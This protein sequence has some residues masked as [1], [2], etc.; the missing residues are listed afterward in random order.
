MMH[1]M[2]RILLTSL[3][4]K[5]NVKNWQLKKHYLSVQLVHLLSKWARKKAEDS[6]Q[7]VSVCFQSKP[8]EKFI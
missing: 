4:S 5:L 8:H 7:F 6:M 2:E 1:K 3:Q